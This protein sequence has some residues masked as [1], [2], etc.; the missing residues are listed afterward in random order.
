VPAVH[1]RTF[2][3]IVESAQAT[4]QSLAIENG[5]KGLL[6][7]R[8]GP[9]KPSL[10][11]S[12]LQLHLILD[13]VASLKQSAGALLAHRAGTGLLL[14]GKP[15]LDQLHVSSP[16][17]WL[18]ESLEELKRLRRGLASSEIVFRQW[19]LKPQPR[20]VE[21]RVSV[22]SGGDRV[23][24]LRSTARSADL[25][26]LAALMF[27]PGEKALLEQ[28]AHPL[29]S[30]LTTPVSANFTS[31]QWELVRDQCLEILDWRLEQI[32]RLL[33]HAK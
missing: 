11:D 1:Q 23:T 31:S 10:I 20:L 2:D 32:S 33:Q 15:L 25:H 28:V 14:V 26:F 5:R 9:F 12:F 7:L 24:L 19:Q 16:T 30:Q 27:A 13:D 3:L 8:H 4:I 17:S 29:L 22:T 21:G 18:D 6:E